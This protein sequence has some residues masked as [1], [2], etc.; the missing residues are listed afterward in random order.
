MHQLSFL[1]CLAA[2]IACGSSRTVIPETRV[3]GEAHQ[4]ERYE[5]ADRNAVISVRIDL[6]Q[7]NLERGYEHVLRV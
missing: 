7:R 2:S 5:I 6:A 3:E 1:L 4:W